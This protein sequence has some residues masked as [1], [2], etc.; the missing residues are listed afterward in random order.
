[1]KKQTTIQCTCKSYCQA[2]L[3]L[4]VFLP[5][6]TPMSHVS[7]LSVYIQ[8]NTIKYNI[9]QY[10]TIP[11][12]T[13]QYHT[14]QYNTIQYNNLFKVDHV[15]K[16]CPKCILNIFSCQ[17]NWSLTSQ[18]LTMHLYFRINYEFTQISHLNIL[19]GDIASIETYIVYLILRHQVLR[20]FCPSYLPFITELFSTMF[21]PLRMS[22]RS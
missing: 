18:F 4:N 3:V 22:M 12:H 5:T 17:Q 10:N 19:L 8:Y 2:S 6:P 9:I 16:G 21:R 1:M 11:Y 15:R 13:I 20:C 7:C 14:I